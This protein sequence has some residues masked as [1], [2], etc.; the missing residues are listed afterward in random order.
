MAARRELR[1]TA[2]PGFSPGRATPVSVAWEALVRQP[3]VFIVFLVVTAQADCKTEGVYT[4]RCGEVMA[5]GA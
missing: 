3:S 5:A 1:S 4:H 2:E